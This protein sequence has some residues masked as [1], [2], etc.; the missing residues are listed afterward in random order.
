MRRLYKIDT[1]EH[2]VIKFRKVRKSFL[3]GLQ[4]WLQ[5]IV[6]ISC[7]GSRQFVHVNANENCGKTMQN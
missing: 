3:M 1:K 5:C 2:T 7:Y 4:P 6:C